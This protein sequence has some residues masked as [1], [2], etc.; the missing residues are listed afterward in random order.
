MARSSP[1]QLGRRERQIVEALYKLGEA[2]VAQVK[3]ELPDPPS[4]SAVRAVLNLLV[5]KQIVRSRSQGK[6]YLYRAAAPKHAVRLSALKNL[7]ATFFASAPIDAVAALLDGSAGK[8][9]DEDLR[10]V[11]QMIE[12]AERQRPAGGKP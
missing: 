6:R 9:S 7:V 12:Q 2:S 1:L 10:R 3:A 4:Y 5:E 8:L 11:R